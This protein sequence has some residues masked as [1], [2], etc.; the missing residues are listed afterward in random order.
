VE[1]EQSMLKLYGHLLPSTKYAAPELESSSVVPSA[2]ADAWSLG[3]LIWNI[4]NGSISNSNQLE[5]RGKIP[6]NLFRYSKSLCVSNPGTRLDFQKFL[7]LCLSSKGYFDDPFISCCMFLEQ[8]ALK[9]KS[10]KEDFLQ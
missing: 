9:E 6:L 5:T 10:E 7:K 2:A 1:G 4:F 3:C 8:F